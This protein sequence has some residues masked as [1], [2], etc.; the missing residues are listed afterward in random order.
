VHNRSPSPSEGNRAISRYLTHG[1]DLLG[2]YRL[3]LRGSDGFS[4]SSLELVLTFVSIHEMSGMSIKTCASFKDGHVK[5]NRGVANLTN[6]LRVV[7]YKYEIPLLYILPAG[8]NQRA[9]Y[10]RVVRVGQLDLAHRLCGEPDLRPGS[11][12]AEAPGCQIARQ[13]E[14]QQLEEPTSM[15][16][17]AFLIFACKR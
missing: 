7:Y 13:P 8:C 14:S 6:S 2:R 5:V 17:G 12:G 1:P 4:P 9:G 3:Q 15:N 11:S 10:S 16:E